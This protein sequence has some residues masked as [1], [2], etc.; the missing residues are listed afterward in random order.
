[1]V[2][3]IVF[4]Y[5]SY[6]SGLSWY[7]SVVRP[8]SWLFWA[9]PGSRDDRRMRACLGPSR[10]PGRRPCT[11]RRCAGSAAPA[12]SG[13]TGLVG[14]FTSWSQNLLAKHVCVCVFVYRYVYTSMFN[15]RQIYRCTYIHM[16]ICI[17][18]YIYIY[19]RVRIHMYVH[20]DQRGTLS[21]TWDSINGRPFLESMCPGNMLPERGTSNSQPST[22]GAGPCSFWWFRTCE[23]IMGSSRTAQSRQPVPGSAV[24]GLTG[25]S[26][27]WK[28]VLILVCG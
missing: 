21:N 1:M 23:A 12:A 2:T 24:V 10:R 19:M 4:R 16:Y 6:A 14:A 18:I 9:L 28:E 22:A 3:A 13:V 25:L 27:Y 11:A 5:F 17:C 7:I 26:L 15:R 20:M 8:I